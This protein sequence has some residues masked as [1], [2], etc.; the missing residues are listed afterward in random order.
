MT[1]I[2]SVDRVRA[3][4]PGHLTAFF[5]VHHD[6]DPRRSGSRGAGIAVADG[7]SVTVQPVDGVTLNDGPADIEAVDRVLQTFEVP[8]QASV[9]TELPIGMGCGVSGAA[10]LATALA[11]DEATGA[12]ISRDELITR[13]HVADV[14]AGTGLGD[15]VAQ[16]VGGATIRVE[17]GAP[18]FGELRRLPAEGRV[19]YLPLGQI[20]TTEVLA[21]DT[22]Q[23]TRDGEAI[24]AELLEE[25]SLERLIDLGH[26]FAEQIDVIDAELDTVLTAIDASGGRACIG[27]LGRTVVAPGDALTRAGYDP[28]VTRIEPR[29]AAVVDH[30]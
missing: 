26:Q 14:T 15:V 16:A 20:S 1:D 28:V 6:E 10:A 3:E 4:A 17:P 18:P 2:E 7:V 30:D 29:G 9:E 8:L 13:A 27:L 24:L 5:S 12:G 23:L 11:A 19:E 21:G 25:P 22:D